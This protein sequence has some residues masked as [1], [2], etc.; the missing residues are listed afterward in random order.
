LAT[1][2]VTASGATNGELNADPG[3]DQTQ[4]GNKRQLY[5]LRP[6]AQEYVSGNDEQYE[7][8]G[9]NEQRYHTTLPLQKLAKILLRKIGRH[10]VA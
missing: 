1:E 7:D 2:P 9:T 8:P 4:N 3:N 10:D 5:D 6:R